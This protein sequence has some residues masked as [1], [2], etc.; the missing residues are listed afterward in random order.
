MMKELHAEEREL[1]IAAA[2]DGELYR[3]VLNEGKWIKAGGQAF[4]ATQSDP[5]IT[6][7]YFTALQK[8]RQRGYVVYKTGIL[9]ELTDS[10][11][12]KARE[13]AAEEKASQQQVEDLDEATP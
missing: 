13:L 4:P 6:A 1:L 12:K 11:F 2:E 9:Y 5:A 8:L 10:G 7:T 3:M